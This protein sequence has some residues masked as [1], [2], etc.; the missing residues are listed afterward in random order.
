M[1]RYFY[2]PAILQ[3]LKIRHKIQEWRDLK[4]FSEM[5]FNVG[6]FY[7][8]VNIENVK[9]SFVSETR[10]CFSPY[11]IALLIVAGI[12]QP[13]TN[14]DDQVLSLH[15]KLDD[16]VV[17]FTSSESLMSC[18]L[19]VARTPLRSGWNSGF[20]QVELFCYF[21]TAR[22]QSSVQKRRQ[23]RSDLQ[24]GNLPQSTGQHADRWGFSSLLLNF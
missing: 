4:L 17:T 11:W 7:I 8:F 18:R 21:R 12:V 19:S 24:V 9:C 13:C 23:T 16:H 20:I 2:C 3:Y 1:K 15:V 10:V 22:W 6:I 14:S 5:K